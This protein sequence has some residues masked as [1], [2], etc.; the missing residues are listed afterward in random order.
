MKL[1]NL[2]CK[3]WGSI[4]EKL[5]RDLDK[6]NYKT[7][8][9]LIE[10]L[11]IRYSDDAPENIF[12]MYYPRVKSDEPLPTI[13]HV[14]GGAYVSGKLE[15]TDEYCRLLAE[16]G[17]C[18]INME[19]VNSQKE[20]FP[21]PVYDVFRLFKFLETNEIN[22]HIDFDNFFMSGDSAGGH[23]ASL[24]ANIQTNEELKI[25][26]NLTGG[27]KIKG[28]ILSSAMM[29][30]YRFRGLWPKQVL[31]DIVFKENSKTE[32]VD[33]S[34]NLNNLTNKFPPTIMISACNDFIKTHS[35]IFTKIAPEYNLYAEHWTMTSGKHLKHDVNIIEP[36]DYECLVANS[37]IN[38]FIK[39]IVNNNIQ[40]GQQGV[41]KG[42]INS[43]SKIDAGFVYDKTKTN[44]YKQE[45]QK[46][47]ENLTIEKI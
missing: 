4:H 19:F 26:Y 17:Y 14:H 11:N 37:K 43:K 22:K 10:E 30:V 29:G 21:R 36:Y 20:G 16:Q 8:N 45:E 39:N 47:L 42:K 3:V 25:N 9:S 40:Q 28:C 15:L 13:V 7:P 31:E 1:E 6:K 33:M 12:N 23:V 35:N 41:I 24:V 18:V 32:I 27:P 44:F 2:Y 38:S 34:H 46:I 5:Y